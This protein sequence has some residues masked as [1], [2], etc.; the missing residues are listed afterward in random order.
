MKNITL[1]LIYA[2]ISIFLSTST[3][4]ATESAI[5]VRGLTIQKV[6][7]N[8]GDTIKGWFGRSE[9]QYV[10]KT[11]NDLYIGDVEEKKSDDKGSTKLN[12]KVYSPFTMDAFVEVFDTEN[13]IREIRVIEGY[14]ATEDL[15]SALDEL[16]IKYPA[17]SLEYNII[18]PIQDYKK[19]DIEIEV[20][21]GERA[22]FSTSSPNVLIYNLVVAGLNLTDF[23]IGLTKTSETKKLIASFVKE[24][25]VKG[26][27]DIIALD[28]TRDSRIANNL[29]E[30]PSFGRLMNDFNKFLKVGKD[31]AQA[32]AVGKL[33]D[34]VE[35]LV[36][37]LGPP[38]AFTAAASKLVFGAT[39]VSNF[40]LRTSQALDQYGKQKPPFSL[41]VAT[42]N[43]TL[44]D[45]Q[46][47]LPESGIKLNQQNQ[48]MQDYSSCI[49]QSS[50]SH[51]GSAS[52]FIS[53]NAAQIADY[54]QRDLETSRFPSLQ[55]RNE[56]TNGQIVSAPLDI[57]LTWDQSNKLDLDSHL[58]TPT[59]EHVYFSQR[60]DLNQS[61]NSFLYRDSIPNGGL[62]GAEQTRI[63]Q[64]QQ[65]EYRFYVYNYS[66]ADGQEAARLAGSNGLS[67]SGAT[68]KLYEGGAPLTN[69]PNDPAVFDLNNPNVQKVGAPYPGDSTFK[70]PV[71][72]TGNTWYV[73]KLNTRT[74]ILYRIDR[75]GNSPDSS[76]VPN[77]R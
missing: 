11:D 46:S 12:F 76:S 41:A 1:P 13:K 33:S 10:Y 17:K 56:Y 7:K 27:I 53:R 22:D 2:V 72:Q 71:N 36:A 66:E 61:P 3:V 38:G 59:N 24:L 23:G 77:V 37:K 47:W 51:V 57:G 65:G 28:L 74:G 58:V 67:N 18:N 30:S 73:F 9:D 52:C 39:K 62:K 29:L 4:I 55:K 49:T 44:N 40:T 19:T 63:S 48:A 64:F 26:E 32:V 43:Q 69:I 70:V 6:P 31:S 34:Q 15:I 60:G 45:W 16:M 68:V 25:Y 42:S 50:A 5:K 54:K 14:S 75:F 8:L 35:N 20:K 21:P